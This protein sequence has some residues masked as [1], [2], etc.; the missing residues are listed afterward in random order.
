MRFH[1]RAFTLV[2]LLVVIGII[3]L[4][5]SI[6]LPTLN[7]A[8]E[9][10]NSTKCLS[11]LKQINMALIMYADAN[12]GY[13]P[14]TNG[15][16][17]T[18]N[19]NGT[20]RQVAVRWY[21]GAYGPGASP[22]VTNGDFWGPAS[23]LTPYWGTASVSGCPTFAHVNEIF[24]KG[25]GPVAYAYNAFA[26]H[27][28]ATV[29]QMPGFTFDTRV[30]EKLSRFKRAA[31]KAAVWDSARVPAGETILDRTPWGYPTSGNPNPSANNPDPNF[32]GRHGQYGN[33]GWFDGH[34]SSF[35]PRYFDSYGGNTADPNILR[36]LHIGNI[37]SDGDLKTDEH[38]LPHR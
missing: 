19:V 15:G 17:Q 14:P 13:L 10:A 28:F 3:A 9:A 22:N 32:H 5:V 6:L 4:L 20:E 25:Y 34:A 23:P 31:D 33:V 11:N 18:M 8:R 24:R 29:A 7:K 35:R 21:G 2:E 36:K 27:Q 38:Y 12:R 30:G 16:T 1:P 37:D 26:G